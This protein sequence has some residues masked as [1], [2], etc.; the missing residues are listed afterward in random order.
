MDASTWVGIASV[1]A[2][3]GAAVAAIIT[4]MGQ[5]RT[6]MKVDAVHDEVKTTNGKTLG[7]IA[8]ESDQRATDADAAAAATK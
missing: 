5:N 7:M 3:V 4:A 8:S 2:A 1:I 6:N